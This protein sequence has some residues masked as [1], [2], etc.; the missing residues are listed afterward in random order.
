MALTKCPE[1][2]KEVSTMATACPSCGYPIG[3][4]FSPKGDQLECEYCKKMI[5]SN[6][7]VCPYCN[8]Q[9]FKSHRQVETMSPY[10]KPIEKK[11]G[12]LWML[13]VGV[14]IFGGI[15]SS[16]TS[17]KQNE[18]SGPI[19]SVKS[20]ITSQPTDYEHN[21]TERC[22]DWIYYRNKAYKLGREG[23]AAGSEKA[24]IAM[25]TFDRDL[26]KYFTDK[27]IGDEIAR[28]ESGGQ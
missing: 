24:R 6:L 12:Y 21:L 16:A 8:V 3:S 2:A 5:N 13:L 28:L 20:P 10:R 18:H 15:V 22:K 19:V 7:S 1:C 17:D 26:R 4:E 14:V 25:I 9:V 27:Q 23:D 11:T